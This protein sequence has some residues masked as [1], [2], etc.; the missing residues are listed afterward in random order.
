M[1]ISIT[2]QRE[3]W[4]RTWPHCRCY[5]IP[6][7]THSKIEGEAEKE[8]SSLLGQT[9]FPSCCTVGLWVSG[10]YLYS[11]E[12]EMVA[13]RGCPIEGF[14]PSSLSPK[15]MLLTLYTQTKC[16]SKQTS[17]LVNKL[18]LLWWISWLLVS[19]SWQSAQDFI[20]GHAIL[21]AGWFCLGLMLFLNVT[22]GSEDH[23]NSSTLGWR[24]LTW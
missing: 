3:M 8:E 14:K 20:S 5:Y 4:H 12:K 1:Y 19:T 15:S 22:S 18:S 7:R 16:S 13:Q 21:E 24:S 23:G 11:A 17:K 10:C 6:L 9:L 2:W